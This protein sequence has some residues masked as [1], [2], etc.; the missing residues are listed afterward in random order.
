MIFEGNYRPENILNFDETAISRDYVGNT[1]IALTGEKN[2]T[3]RTAGRE[4]QNYTLGITTN[5]AGKLL[6]TVVVWP[7]K[8]ERNRPTEPK[9]I[10]L[11]YRP[12]GSWYDI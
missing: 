4:K 5:L 7:T 9:N 3:V 2:V 12:K 8:G 6:K 1:T 11:W 10:S